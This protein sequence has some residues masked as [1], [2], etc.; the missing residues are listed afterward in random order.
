MNHESL[1]SS[2]WPKPEDDLDGPLILAKILRAADRNPRID[3]DDL[4]SL[5]WD[6]YQGD[7]I[8][9]IRHCSVTE[10]SRAA[11][12]LKAALGWITR[13]FKVVKRGMKFT[14]AQATELLGME[15]ANPCRRDAM[16]RCMVIAMR[17]G[18]IGLIFTPDVLDGLSMTDYARRI[19]VSKQRLD[20]QI[21]QANE[22]FQSKGRFQKS[23]SASISY[24][25]AQMGN[26]NR[27][28]NRANDAQEEFPDQG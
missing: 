17:L 16:A 5:L 12:A 22:H 7:L 14:E 23:E 13:D 1:A 9:V 27:I 15:V 20:I 11:E 26:N 2:Y 18:A 10:D 6:K 28:K 8:E 19:G 21:R 4:A 25:E 24:A 3:R